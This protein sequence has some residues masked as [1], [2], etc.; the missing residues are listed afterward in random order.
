ML[1]TISELLSQLVFEL[2]PDMVGCRVGVIALL[3]GGQ[4]VYVSYSESVLE[5]EFG[6]LFGFG[7]LG[8]F[9]V[10]LLRR[11]LCCVCLERVGGL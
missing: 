9:L 6:A 5:S 10:T 1:S 3:K 4:T 7:L 11:R 8:L 2:V